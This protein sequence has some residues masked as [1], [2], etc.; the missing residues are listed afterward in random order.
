[1]CAVPLSD[2]VQERLPQD[3]H[4]LRGGRVAGPS[5]L[6]PSTLSLGTKGGINGEAIEVDASRNLIPGAIPSIPGN[7]VASRLLS[8]VHQRSQQPASH[9]VDSQVGS[10]GR[11]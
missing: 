6:L 8:F 4:L 3:D 9:V 5:T 1:M 2:C 10:A 11:W 7:R